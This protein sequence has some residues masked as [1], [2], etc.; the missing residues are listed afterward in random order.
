M[1]HSWRSLS[2][3]MKYLNVYIM[4]ILYI[5]K[6]LPLNMERLISILVYQKINRTSCKLYNGFQK[7]ND[8][9]QALPIL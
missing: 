7:K 5:P 9:K 3:N 6:E 2:S 8:D 4:Y 1:I